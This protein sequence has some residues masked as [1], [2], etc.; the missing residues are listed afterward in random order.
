MLQAFK[1]SLTIDYNSARQLKDL[2]F[3]KINYVLERSYIPVE[4]AVCREK[5]VQ[6]QKKIA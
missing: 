5:E 3:V 6:N 2:Q 1:N 4:K